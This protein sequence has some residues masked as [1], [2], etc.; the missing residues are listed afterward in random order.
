M[1]VIREY[2]VNVCRYTADNKLKSFLLISGAIF[3]GSYRLGDPYVPTAKERM[4]ELQKK[5]N[6]EKIQKTETE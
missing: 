1:G 5:Q 3:L 4:E 2:W 6:N